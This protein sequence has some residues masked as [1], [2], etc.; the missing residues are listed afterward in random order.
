SRKSESGRRHEV[1]FYS[2]EESFLNGGAHFIGSALK[3]GD[4]AIVVATEP[5]RDGVLRRL[6]ARGLDVVAAKE[7][8]RYISVDA[9][10]ALSTFMV[11]SLLNSAQFRQCLSELIATAAKATGK[12][13][14]RVAVFG[15]CVHLL[16]AE[17]NPEAAIQMEQTAN[18]LASTYDVDL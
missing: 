6:Q 4:A 2:S 16:C 1:H 17:G 15:E 14:P 8:G 10:D 18:Q 5:H 11:D 13:Q 9:A 7:Q 12:E 3:A